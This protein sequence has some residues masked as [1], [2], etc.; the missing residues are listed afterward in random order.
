MKL[1]NTILFLLSLEP[2]KGQNL[3]QLEPVDPG[4]PD[5]YTLNK[6][7]DNVDFSS[8]TVSLW[9]Q[10]LNDAYFRNTNWQSTGFGGSS[11]KNTDFTGA[12]LTSASGKCIYQAFSFYF[13]HL[14]FLQI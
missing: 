14:H 5:C 4:W 7:C 6:N 8:L 1:I 12:I 3:R 9:H 11:A 10:T 13:S 2:I